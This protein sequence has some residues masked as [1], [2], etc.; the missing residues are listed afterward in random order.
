MHSKSDKTLIQPR[1]EGVD[2][3]AL[4]AFQ[5]A[6]PAFALRVDSMARIAKNEDGILRADEVEAL[7]EDEM[8]KFSLE[9]IESWGAKAS[10]EASA[11]AAT[12]GMAKHKK[13]PDLAVP[14]RHGHLRGD[15]IPCR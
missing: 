3:D 2:L 9:L 12:S 8:R 14:I 15:C 4:F 7:V 1:K 11:R 13:K 10:S 6:N 5:R